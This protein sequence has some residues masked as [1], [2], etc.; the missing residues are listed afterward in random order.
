[1]IKLIR[2]K[3]KRAFTLIELVVVIAVIAILAGVSVAAYFGV[4]NSAR[5]SAALQEGEQ[6]STLVT[7]LATDGEN[8]PVNSKEFVLTYKINGLTVD[9]DSAEVTK[10]DLNDIFDYI[11]YFGAEGQYTEN[12]DARFTGENPHATLTFYGDVTNNTQTGGYIV[13]IDGFDYTLTTGGTA[14]VG[15]SADFTAETKGNA[16]LTA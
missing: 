11:Y 4:T 15:L 12:T 10:D 6:L 8:V 16:I 9:G 5:N 7:T 14:T 13:V 3:A 1:M 2:T